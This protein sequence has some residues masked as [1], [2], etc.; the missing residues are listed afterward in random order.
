[1]WPH[2]VSNEED[3]YEV[4]SENIGLARFFSC[5]TFIMLSCGR[6]AESKG[7]ASLLHAVSK[8]CEYLPW[9]E[10][11]TFHNIMMLK[12]EQDR[13]NW[14]SDFTALADEYV[15]KKVRLSLRAKSASA[16]T[17]YYKSF[18][19]RGSSNARGSYNYSYQGKSGSGSNKSLQEVI[20]W[21]WNYSSCSYGDRCKRW[22]ACRTCAE[23]G[24]L[25]E[26][27]KASSHANS[28]LKAK[29]GESRG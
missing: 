28:S 21:Q 17:N 26:P 3:G 27:H 24:K 8:V 22:H 13:I 6:A 2:T 25:G 5:F 20:C 18:D 10:A 19:Q 14:L 12:I 4:D 29:P 16:D 11:R 15:D 7:R 1:M 9:S 23:A